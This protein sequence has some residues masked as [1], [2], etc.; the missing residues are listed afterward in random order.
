MRPGLQLK[1]LDGN[2]DETASSCGFPAAVHEGPQL[3]VLWCP[4]LAALEQKMRP[5]L[6]LKQLDGKMDESI[7][8]HGFPAA[9]HEGPQVWAGWW[10]QQSQ[11]VSVLKWDH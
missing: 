6:Q 11:E 10:L 1:Q 7:S 3:S 9:I 5:G 4:A 2:M 8:S